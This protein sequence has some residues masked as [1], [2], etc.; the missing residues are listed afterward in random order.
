[1][2]HFDINQSE[3]A[4]DLEISHSYVS[5]MLAGTKVPSKKLIK[6]IK[7]TYRVLDYWWQT[8][9]GDITDGNPE[10]IIPYR[11]LNQEKAK[12]QLI[13]NYI[14]PEFMTIVDNLEVE[15][16]KVPFE[17]RLAAVTI[18]NKHIRTSLIK[19]AKEFLATSDYE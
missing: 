1:M 6:A 12:L 5:A 7:K 17:V 3:F 11:E 10:D 4:D 15:L 14:T 18:L 9:E 2:E 19:E 13:Q 8:G 16:S